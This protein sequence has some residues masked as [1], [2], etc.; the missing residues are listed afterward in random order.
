MNYFQRGNTW[1]CDARSLGFGKFS[2]KTS[3]KTE[4]K[5]YARNKVA[6]EPPRLARNTTSDALKFKTNGIT[7]DDAFNRAMRSEWK[8]HAQPKSIEAN[9]KYCCDFFGSTKLL[10]DI[11]QGLLSD[12][13]LYLESH[14]KLNSNSSI[15]KKIFHLSGLMKLARDQWGFDRVPKL[16]LNTKQQLNSRWFIYTDEQLGDLKAYFKTKASNGHGDSLF[17]YK[18]VLF[19]SETGCRLSEGLRFTLDDYQGDFIRIWKAKGDKPRA[20]PVSTPLKALFDTG[21]LKDFRELKIHQVEN[22]F[23]NARKNITSLPQEADIHS[24]RHTFATR[25]VEAGVPIQVLQK[26]LGHSRIETTMIY[27]KMADK[28][29]LDAMKLFEANRSQ[30]K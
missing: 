8:N 22:R 19:L 17:M 6:Q 7:L 15:N 14:P 2:C 28:Q 5:T 27:V 11:N 16:H 10:Q 25:M 26:I 3:S 24:L 21:K 29:S 20:V 9:H 18:L 23:S 1:Y 4:A 13:K 12:F 30:L